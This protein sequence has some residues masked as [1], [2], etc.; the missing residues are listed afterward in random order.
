MFP[1]GSA[2]AQSQPQTATPQGQVFEEEIVPQRYANNPNVDAF[3]NDIV[4][5]IRHRYGAALNKEGEALRV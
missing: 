4:E 1:A 5:S 3:I 2:F